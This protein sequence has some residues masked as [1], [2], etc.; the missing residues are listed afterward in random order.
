MPVKSGRLVDTRRKILSFVETR[1]HILGPARITTKNAG[2]EH[3]GSNFDQTSSKLNNKLPIWDAIFPG[4]VFSL[5]KK[6]FVSEAH[7]V[8]R[9]RLLPWPS[10]LPDER[11]HGLQ[12]GTLTFQKH[13][14]VTD[15]D[16]HGSKSGSEGIPWQLFSSR[17]SWEEPNPTKTQEIG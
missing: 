14:F 8:V 6:W 7:G 1:H 13:G 16:P 3:F 15:S 12:A 17:I 10:C 9:V 4:C 11:N 2:P 5:G